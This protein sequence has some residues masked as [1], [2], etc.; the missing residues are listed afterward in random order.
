MLL[1][2]KSKLF[3]Y[4]LNHFFLKIKFSPFFYSELNI[5]CLKDVEINLNRKKYKYEN[6]KKYI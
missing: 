2:L 6:K 4:K 1:K 5:Y 3:S